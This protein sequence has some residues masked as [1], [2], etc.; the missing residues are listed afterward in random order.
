MPFMTY[1]QFVE[2]W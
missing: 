2:R 1:V